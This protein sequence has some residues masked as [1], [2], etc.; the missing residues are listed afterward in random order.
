MY[1]ISVFYSFPFVLII[2][3]VLAQA[4]FLEVV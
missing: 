3:Q 2:Q 4:G 1:E